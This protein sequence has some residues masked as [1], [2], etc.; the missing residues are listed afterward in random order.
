MPSPYFAKVPPPSCTCLTKRQ[1][2]PKLKPFWI[3]KARRKNAHDGVTLLVQRDR[4]AQHVRVTAKSA[5]P[6]AVSE[7]G[8]LWAVGR[9]LFPGEVASDGRLDAEQWKEI[10]RHCAGHDLFRRSR[11]G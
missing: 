6:E 2:N 8:R 4:P 9:V 7:N 3:L 11:P 10:R 1:R 5:L